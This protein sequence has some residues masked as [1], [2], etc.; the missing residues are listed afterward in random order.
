VSARYG[1]ASVDVFFLEIAGTTNNLALSFRYRAVVPVSRRP[2]A[3][4]A[5]GDP[6]ST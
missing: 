5:D 4:L 1:V 3:V 2:E 6:V